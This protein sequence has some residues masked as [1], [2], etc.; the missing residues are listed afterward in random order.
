M[1]YTYLDELPVQPA[2]ENAR[3]ALRIARS[4]LLPPTLKINPH[5]VHLMQA[6]DNAMDEQELQVEA[7]FNI[8]N[9][10]KLSKEGEQ[11]VNEGR[12][13][14]SSAFLSTDI[15]NK[16]VALLGFS[17]VTVNALSHESLRRL[18]QNLGTYWFQK[19]PAGLDFLQYCFDG[20]VVLTQMWVDSA[21]CYHKHRDKDRWLSTT[22]EA[23][24]LGNPSLESKDVFSKLF[25]ELCDYNLVLIYG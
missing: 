1:N 24:L 2:A 17:L 8:R 20:D 3:E 6:V 21:G 11:L 10:M 22:V 9:P 7:L 13:L 12:I 18:L 5:F 19:G 14:D 23:V 4:V 15:I 25:Y 16:Q